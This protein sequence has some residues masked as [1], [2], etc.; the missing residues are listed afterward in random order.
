M[1]SNATEDNGGDDSAVIQCTTGTEHMLECPIKCLCSQYGAFETRGGLV[2]S[3]HMCRD[4][5]A[6]P[7]SPRFLSVHRCLRWDC[8][9]LPSVLGF[10]GHTPL[11]CAVLAHNTLLREGCQTLTEEQQK[12][13]QHQSEELESCIHLLVQTGA[14]IYS[15]VR[16][17]LSYLYAVCLYGQPPPHALPDA[18]AVLKL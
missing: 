12:D 3:Q 15:R 9:Y 11:H 10:P 1:S 14:S 13:L 18:C 8:R 17:Q 16:D 5:Y 6:L 7:A 2:P 4:A